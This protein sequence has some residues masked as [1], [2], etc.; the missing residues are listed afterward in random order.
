MSKLKFSYENL[1]IKKDLIK[2]VQKWRKILG[3]NVILNI[4]YDEQKG[5]LHFRIEVIE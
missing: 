1:V 3:A 5:I 2:L 4:T